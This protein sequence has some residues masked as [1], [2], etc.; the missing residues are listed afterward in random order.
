MT[1]YNPSSHISQF[2]TAAPGQPS[3]PS[4]ES[5]MIQPSSDGVAT[6]PRPR[7]RM[8]P[9]PPPDDPSLS[10]IAA[11]STPQSTVAPPSTDAVSSFGN[12]AVNGIPTVRPPSLPPSSFPTAGS[13]SSIPQPTLPV[14]S[15]Q[16]ERSKPRSSKATYDATSSG[17]SNDTA[18][19]PEHTVPPVVTAPKRPR[20]KMRPPPPPE[21]DIHL[22]STNSTIPSVTTTNSFPNFSTNPS[23]SATTN[24]ASLK[25]SSAQQK[26]ALD[27]AEEYTGRGARRLAQQSKPT[28]AEPYVDVGGPEDEVIVLLDSSDAERNA[29]KPKTKSK[30]KPKK[31]SAPTPTPKETSV[32]AQLDDELLAL[33][34]STSTR[35]VLAASS[36][37]K[38]KS[39]GPPRLDDDVLGDWETP[40]P[41]APTSTSSPS[42]N[43]KRRKKMVLRDPDDE[44]APATRSLA[45]AHV[46]NT[47]AQPLTSPS[48]P[49]YIRSSSPL[50]SPG[51]SPQAKRKSAP[52][53]TLDQDSAPGPSKKRKSAGGVLEVVLPGP[54]GRGEGE[55]KKG[56][57]K[58]AKGKNKAPAV[59]ADAS[60]GD[61]APIDADEGENAYVPAVLSPVVGTSSS[62]TKS[63]SSKSKT[64]LPTSSGGSSAIPK[65]TN[66]DSGPVGQPPTDA[67]MDVDPE[68]V[69]PAPAT[70]KQPKKRAPKAK[71]G[72]AAADEA[73]ITEG[74]EV[75]PA[76]GKKKGAKAKAKAKAKA[77]EPIPELASS[78]P[79]VSEPGVP[80]G[81]TSSNPDVVSS[82]PS[83]ATDAAGPSNPVAPNQT[84][85][86]KPSR[87]KPRH[88]TT[89]APLPV[90][91][92]ASGALLR[93]VGRKTSERPLAETLRLALGGTGTPPPRVG[94]SRRGSSKIA[95]LL[96]IRGA[97][98]PPPPPMPKKPVRKKKGQSDDEDSEEGSEWEKL[99]EKQKEKKRKEKE[100]AAWY[101]D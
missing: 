3:V 30:P 18:P 95:P 90:A 45:P 84:P 7:P 60:T 13:F 33:Y 8:R 12:S 70:K 29:T 43:T 59:A 15:P 51:R 73:P 82:N 23:T 1:S 21:P 69:V 48:G 71:K 24:S 49:S 98:P 46:P 19:L 2:P 25:G 50:S 35:P 75:V 57:S 40:V 62:D 5:S 32:S 53:S 37:T 55:K 31:K 74:G 100:M 26:S 63:D 64:T 92:G 41:G 10:S 96:S 61:S 4:M 39:P 91:M 76:T 38:R 65:P 27:D 80:T 47:I 28:T 54:A 68:Q 44:A 87:P 9:I 83:A 22:S 93:S 56:K 52:Q 67:P 72:V 89:P 81:A 77:D 99:T 34:A 101:S 58:A 17:P 78:N 36:S 79:D 66:T 97:P 42:T 16:R 85:A 6:R 88:S 11:F 20:P 86:P 94:L 14:D